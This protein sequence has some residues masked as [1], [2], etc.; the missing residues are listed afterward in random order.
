MKIF[1][2]LAIVNLLVLFSSCEKDNQSRLSPKEN[3]IG[4]YLVEVIEY[5]LQSSQVGEDFVLRTVDQTCSG[6]SSYDDYVQFW[7]NGGGLS[8]NYWCIPLNGY[9]FEFTE[10]IHMTWYGAL[11][12]GEGSFAGGFMHFEGTIHSSFGEGTI[13]LTSS[14]KY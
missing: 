8:P 1:Y 13:V 6:F 12:T 3:L 5:S 2:F 7:Y 11:I 4:Y 9:N 14:E 10:D